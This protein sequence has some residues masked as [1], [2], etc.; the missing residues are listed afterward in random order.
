MALA[1]LSRAQ[2]NPAALQS[3]G[4]G[5]GE[6]L[7]YSVRW[8]IIPSVGRIKISADILGEGTGQVLRVTTT[9]S[10]WGLARGILPFDGRG[11]SIYQ[12]SSGRL[13]TSDQWSSY[14]D[15]V[16]K[17]SVTFDYDN[18]TAAY[19][20]DIHPEKSRQLKMPQGDPSDLILALI[21]TRY[22]DMKPGDKRDAL[23]IFQDQFYQLTIRAQ[24]DPEYVLTSLGLFK[25]TVL[26]P[27]MEKT[28]PLGMFKRGSTVRVWIAQDDP[29]HLPVRFEV[30]FKVGTGTATLLDYQPPK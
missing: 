24:D 22:W 27:R 10:T 17:N 15:K 2:A 13:L 8:G 20:D 12:T 19:T 25:A 28:P 11:E 5:D 18:M 23:V 4:I 7:T 6:V 30:G 29:R 26:V 1:A 16:V 9:T 3:Y 14:R 21:Q